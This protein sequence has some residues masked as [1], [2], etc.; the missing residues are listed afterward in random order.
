MNIRWKKLIASLAV[1]LTVGGLA[2]FAAKDNMIMFELVSKPPL[3][4]PG[5]LF[6]IVW[7][8]LYI[9]MGLAAYRVWISGAQPKVKRLAALYYALSLVFNFGWPVIFFNF[10]RY[11]AAFI[12]LCLL[13]LFALLTA[14]QFCKADNKAGW[15]MLPYLLWVIFAGYLNMGI[16]LLKLTGAEPL[17]V[18][19]G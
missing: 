15:L 12:W 6:P 1:P 16:Y 19:T 8:L 18:L 11:L 10:D 17:P 3:A 4:P 7:T 14:V 5:W 2:G 13:W 9:L